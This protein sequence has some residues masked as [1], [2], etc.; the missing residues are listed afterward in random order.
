MKRFK[1]RTLVI[2]AVIVTV[3]FAVGRAI[4]PLVGS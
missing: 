1:R 4:R 2:V 3:L